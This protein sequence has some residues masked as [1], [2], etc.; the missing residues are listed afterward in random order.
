M[1]DQP[2][3]RNAGKAAIVVVAIV[4]AVIVAVFIGLNAS[5]YRSLQQQQN[6]QDA[7]DSA[8]RGPQDLGTENQQ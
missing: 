4:V 8:K 6:G 3:P 1:T 5:H 7:P 2:P